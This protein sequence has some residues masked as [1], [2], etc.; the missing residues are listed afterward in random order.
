M[1]ILRSPSGSIAGLQN[2]GAEF[3]APPRNPLEAEKTTERR[4]RGGTLPYRQAMEEAERKAYQD[5]SR[6]CAGVQLLQGLRREPLTLAEEVTFWERVL[7]WL[8]RVFRMK[9]EIDRRVR[10]GRM[11]AA[12]GAAQ[13]RE[14]IERVFPQGYAL[15][16]EESE[17]ASARCALS[18]ARW[19]LIAQQHRGR[20][21]MERRLRGFGEPPAPPPITT[22][23]RPTVVLDSFDHNQSTVKPSHWPAVLS[24]ARAILASQ[25][26]SSPIRSIRLVGHA[27]RTGTER[28]NQQL[29]QRRAAAVQRYLSQTLERMRPGS[30]RGITFATQSR[31]ETQ[32]VPGPAERSRRVEVFL[33]VSV[34]KPSPRPSPPPP[35]PAPAPRPVVCPPST[36][37]PTGSVLPSRHGFKFPNSFSITIPLPSPLPSISGSF[38]LCGGM[39]SAA[40]DYFLSCIP[41]PST[42]TIPTSGTPLFNYLLRRQLDSLGSPTFGMVSK[43][44]TWTNLPDTRPSGALPL[45]VPGTAFVPGLQ[46]LTVPEFRATVSSIA[47]GSPVVLG[48]I[49]VGPAAVSIWHNHQVLAYGT[50]IVS[51]SVTNIRIYDPNDP[52]NDGVIIRCEVLAGGARVRC[53]QMWPGGR[54]KTVRGFF[55]MPYSRVTPPCLP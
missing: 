10:E 53:V 43:F 4:P 29:G 25:R 51:P 14:Q 27:D 21:P 9:R 6:D 49:Y 28:Y 16:S 34:S 26:T 35:P 40:L 42:T 30:T 45:L 44:L 47:A 11:T 48:L 23:S 20:A 18:K 50:S 17:M 37:T 5:Y 3:A 24:V 15:G 41:I 7:R 39:S 2:I 8:P 54:T 55:R 22:T 31:G 19:R 1:Y 52:G 13:L 38:G 32:P 46:E 12:D 33:P 36:C